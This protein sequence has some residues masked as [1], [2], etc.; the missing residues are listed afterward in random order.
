MGSVSAPLHVVLLE[1][2]LARFLVVVLVLRVRPSVLLGGE[3]G[4]GGLGG[5]VQA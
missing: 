1:L 5:D 4:L 3:R 2:L